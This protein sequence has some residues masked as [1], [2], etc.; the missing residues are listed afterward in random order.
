ML[1]SC[2]F[3]SSQRLASLV[4]G[5]VFIYEDV[6]LLKFPLPS[7]FFFPLPHLCP[8]HDTYSHNRPI[9]LWVIPE[10]VGLWLIPLAFFSM[11]C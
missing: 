3:L 7:P 5:V 10:T 11:Y 1:H 9:G 2:H 4:S 8:R 6:S